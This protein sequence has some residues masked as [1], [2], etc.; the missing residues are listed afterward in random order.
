MVS[1]IIQMNVEVACNNE[2][3]RCGGSKGKEGIKFIKNTEKDLEKDEDT[4]DIY[5]RI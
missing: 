1:G 2:F 3:M 5:N 4:E